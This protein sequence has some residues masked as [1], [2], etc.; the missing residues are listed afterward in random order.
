MTARDRASRLPAGIE[1]AWGRRPLPRKGPKPGLDLEGIVAAAVNLAQ[2]EGLG[3][4]SMSRVAAALGVSTMALYSYLDTKDELLAL[5][6]DHACGPPPEPLV[7]GKGWRDGLARWAAALFSVYRQHPWAVR[8]PISGVPPAPNQVAWLEAGLDCFAA[9]SLTVQQKLSTV[10]LLSV[11]VRSEASLALDLAEARQQ[12]AA[13]GEPA[14]YGQL[15]RALIEPDRFPGVWTAV[16][17]GAFDDDAGMD[18]E[19]RFGLE[20]ILD[21]IAVLLRTRDAADDGRA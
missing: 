21:G 9:T 20:R 18:G 1:R 13:L 10:L 4:V 3:A 15:I 2:A 19:F 14:G 16:S 11:F 8:V 5:M 7:A 6:V 12:A 17:T